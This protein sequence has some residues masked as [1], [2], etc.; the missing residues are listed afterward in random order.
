M[1][2]TQISKGQARGISKLLKGRATRISSC[3]EYIEVRG[4]SRVQ[5]IDAMI[6]DLASLSE[7]V[8]ITLVYVDQGIYDATK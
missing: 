1:N 4:T 6:N 2:A 5:N 8:G 3:G 7:Q